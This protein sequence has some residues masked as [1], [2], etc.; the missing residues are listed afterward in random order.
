MT[1]DVLIPAVARF[2]SDRGRRYFAFG[3]IGVSLWGRPGTT[4]DLD[5]VLS[6][7]RPRA[8]DVIMELKRLGFRVTKPLARKLAEGRIIK[9]PA[10]EAELDLKLCS[11]EHDREALERAAAA[12]FAGF[13]LR[14][15]SPEDI[16]LYK[17]QTWRRQDQADIENLLTNRR[18]LDRAYIVR[19]LTP[20][21]RSTGAPMRERW[22]EIARPT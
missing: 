18:R 1:L 11:T 8:R 15:A 7:E 9:L 13:E 4:R 20:L 5:L 3:G 17:L 12:T 19:H 16:I 2:L 6:L 21:E 10:G 22:E 14:V